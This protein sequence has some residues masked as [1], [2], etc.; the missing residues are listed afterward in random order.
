[1]SENFGNVPDELKERDQWL[2]WD[3]SNDT[4]KQPHW[5]GT[6]SISWSDP[7]DWHSF[8]EA[9]EAAAE[10]DSWG[11]GYVMAQDNDDYA[12]G[13]YSCLDLDGCLESRSSPKDWLPSLEPF[14]ED[15]AYIEYS[16][17][18]DGLHIPLVGQDIPDWWTDSHLTDEEHEGVDVLTNKFCTFTGDILESHDPESVSD[19]D[20]T[21]WLHDAYHALNGEYPRTE[22]EDDEKSDYSDD[23]WEREEIKKALDALDSNCAYPKWRNI[24]FAVHDWDSSTTGKS[25]FESWSRGGGWDDQSQQYIDQIWANSEEG[26]GVTVGTLIHHAMDAGWQPSGTEP[27][28]D[29]ATEDGT[30]AD[31]TQ[32]TEADGGVTTQTTQESAVSSLEN[33]VRDA[34][35]LAE[36]DEIQ[37]KTARHRIARS[38]CIKHDFLYPE[39]SVRGWRSTLYVF[40]AD[41]GVY[42]PR[43]EHFIKG[44]LERFCGDFVTNQTT[45]EVVEKIRRMS[46]KRGA[47]FQTRPERMVVGNGILDLHTGELDPYSPDELHRTKIDVDWNPDAGEPDAIDDFL[48][49]IVDD[50]D[51]NTLYRLIAHAL[52][53]EYV[54]EKAAMLIGSGQNGKSVFLDFVEQFLQDENVTHRSLQD[55]DDNDFAA[56]QL[57]GK[58]A[59]V[60]PDMGDG[61]VTDLSTFKKL[62]GRD[63]MLADVKYEKP[64]QF[65]NH[66]TLVFA[67]NEMPIF[68]EDNHA[69]WRRWLYIDF[70]Y[71]FDVNDQQAKDPEPKRVIMDRLTDQRELEAL[72][73]RCQ[74]EIQEWHAG[75]RDWFA[76]AMSPEAVREKMKK[77]AEPVYNFASACLEPADDDEF[78]DKATM[79]NCYRNYAEEEDLSKLTDNKFGEQLLSLRD[80][81]METQ[82]KRVA[83]GREYVYTGI[84]LSARGRQIMGLDKNT[85][86]NQAD[87][88][89]DWDSKKPVVMEE[90]RDM[91]EDNG[92]DPVPRNGLVWRCASQMG[93][94]TADNVVGELVTEGEIME[95]E[96]GVIPLQ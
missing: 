65:E 50:S 72:L 38:F 44:R 9:V 31:T 80:Y 96:D 25:L 23:D 81:Q 4:P 60:H 90:L 73:V 71:T 89:G 7:D 83:G 57:E 34:I 49:E 41:E 70:P 88:N 3:Q 29:A 14:I 30:D 13:L 77:A 68:R 47:A 92:N 36:E 74:Q 59:N 55:F 27:K 76:D 24:A 54:T 21:P 43:G 84:K 52:Y 87:M 86:E 40:N 2:M 6:F 16:P 19:V 45:N 56:N 28:L 69:V 58:L 10:K 22:A 67:A 63:T 32:Q 78:V 93:K 1:M 79:R 5:R 61:T 20:P 35:M 51:V 37:M 91:V 94:A 15:D 33:E 46:I 64:I 66:A 82:R 12:R 48:H 53:K 18:G 8:D 42:E 95:N 62:T 17:S 26:N 11:I 39:E 85:D 75:G